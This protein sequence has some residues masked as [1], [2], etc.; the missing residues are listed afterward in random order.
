[1]IVQ[2][3]NPLC[4]FQRVIS[5]KSQQTFS[6]Y[7]DLKLTK[8]VAMSF[9]KLSQVLLISIAF[10][11]AFNHQNHHLAHS[12]SDFIQEFFIKNSIEF[13]F[14]HYG[15][16]IDFMADILTKLQQMNHQNYSYNLRVY[17]N[18]SINYGI[19][20]SA[21]LFCDTFDDLFRFSK[22]LVLTNDFWKSLKFLVVLPQ[23]F[24]TRLE[25]QFN[26]D[27][28]NYNLKYTHDM[29]DLSQ[30]VSYTFA[31][32]TISI[33]PG[34]FSHF[35]FFLI[36]T[37]YSIHLATFEWFIEDHCNIPKLVIL[38]TYSRVSQKWMKE[39]KNYEKFG[40]FTKCVLTHLSQFMPPFLYIDEHEIV[41]SRKLKGFTVD[42]LDIL[43]SQ[44]N[45]LV[46]YDSRKENVTH[47]I[48]GNIKIDVLPDFF[49]FE[50][51]MHSTMTFTEVKYEF[52][53]TP[54]ELFTSYEKI[55]MP[56]DKPTWLL[57]VV[58][59]GIAY[60]V[61]LIV[62]R[63]S[64]KLQN[65]VFGKKIATPSLNVLRSFFGIALFRVPTE[66]FP[67]FL[68]MMFILFCI[69]IRTAYQG[70]FFEIMTTNPRRS[71]PQ[72]IDELIAQNF[73]INLIDFNHIHESWLG[74]DSRLVK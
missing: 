60:M 53:I 54:G 70:V 8:S 45:F 38:N 33:L 31:S 61:I 51:E 7:C 67:R 40:D 3:E 41:N 20:N 28:E 26:P 13:N 42:M 72:T 27:L 57:V 66:N 68:L 22:N 69:I 39:F 50:K 16:N 24:Y 4:D 2:V 35:E 71:T 37:E 63:L 15:K 65:G 5:K 12:V 18:G 23:I 46:E 73:T 64:N 19:S 1:M 56:F 47:S 62:N 36:S 29:I 17:S 30:F 25:K 49:L 48:F 59:F 44:G 43:S 14:Y 10:I 9:I 6:F 21:V 34:R 58:T 52:L 32:R 11:H 55:L 74:N